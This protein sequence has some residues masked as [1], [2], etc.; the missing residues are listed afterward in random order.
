MSEALRR[1]VIVDHCGQLSGG[2][3]ALLRLLPHLQQYRPHVLL[4]E[5]GPF[6]DELR[7]A[8]VD[9][10]VLPLDERTRGASRHAGG[11]RRVVTA[12][13]DLGS[14]VMRLARRLRELRPAVV[15]GN[16][17]KAG[18]YGSLAAQLARVPFVWHLRDRL[19][20][21][22]LPAAKIRLTRAVMRHLASGVV[23][24]SQAALETAAIRPGTV[25]NLAI[26][27]AYRRTRPVPPPASTADDGF[28]VGIVGR[29]APWKGQDV[30]L[31]AFARLRQTQPAARARV[32]GTA[33]FDDAPYGAELRQAAQQLGVADAVE[34][35][36][37]RKDVE[38]ELD[39]LSVLV[40][41][42]TIPEPFG[43]VVVEGMAAALPVVATA[44][45][46]PL[47]IIEPGVTGLLYPPGDDEALAQCLRRL[48]QNPALRAKLGEGG[49]QSAARFDPEILSAKLEAFWTSLAT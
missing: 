18:Y 23:A 20:P 6:A 12:G 22:Y 10:E 46:G 49:R 9:V 33:M 13:W 47:E 21:D 26:P 15:H 38:A 41:A 37:F 31:R 48:G 7:A 1:V 27:D 8:D 17:L 3:I 14:Y 4:A 39:R 28:T 2:E 40:H 24:C 34:F 43:Q 44:A 16:S 29:L 11:A 42:S 32:I 45:G 35:T 25:P 30:F 5:E 36:G 19:A